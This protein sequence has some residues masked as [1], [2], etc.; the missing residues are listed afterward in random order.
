[1]GQM[2][3]TSRQT[4]HDHE[5]GRRTRARD[6]TEERKDHEKRKAS[7]PSELEEAGNRLPQLLQQEPAA[8]TP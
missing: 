2:P 3:W 1:M 4:L 8:L 7:G 6:R 5:G